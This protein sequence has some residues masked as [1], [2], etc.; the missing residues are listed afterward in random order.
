M[1]VAPRSRET[2]GIDVVV[3]GGYL[4]S[5][6]TTLVNQLLSR[7]GDVRFAVL[8]NDFG[9]IAIDAG[10]IVSR[11]ATVIGIAGGCVCCA[12]GSDLIGALQEVAA[13][14]EPPSMILVETSGVALP[15]G[16]MQSVGLVRG[17]DAAGIVVV[18]DS[19]TILARAADRFVADTVSRQIADADLVLLNKID[20]VTGDEARDAERWIRDVNP[21]AGLLRTER[22][23]VVLGEIRPLLRRDS[24]AAGWRAVAHRA[25]SDYD[26]VSF[27]PDFPIDIDRLGR[28]LAQPRHRLL[29]AKG[30]V[31]G[32]D[33]SMHALQVAGSW[34]EASP[35]SATTGTG[36]VCIARRGDLDRAAL[37]RL[38]ES[39]R[40][41]IGEI[42]G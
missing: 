40:I 31:R 36:V 4:G 38:L 39:C 12:Y 29:R 10:L 2:A 19:T 37:A 25:D 15:G 6:K 28:E 17:L 27:V 32:A 11:S 13:S 14:A 26:S 33:G 9:A 21:A 34:W 30:I 24:A 1:P 16:V 7:A 41:G 5:G 42:S 23:R 8:V 3:I 20:A 35:S 22:A 18:A